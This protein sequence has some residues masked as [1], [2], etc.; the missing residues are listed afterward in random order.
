V[1]APP[2]H[3]AA[4]FS[5]DLL[6]QKLP[7]RGRRSGRLGTPWHR[8]KP[9]KP[10]V[11]PSAGGT[12]ARG[13]AH[14]DASAPNPLAP[15]ATPAHAHLVEPRPGAERGRDGGLHFP[16]GGPAL[17][18]SEQPTADMAPNGSG[19]PNGQA[20]A[21][22]SGERFEFFAAFREAAERAREEAGIDDRRVGQ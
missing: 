16:P 4:I 22:D 3:A 8:E 5:E 18:G 11:L 10:Q 15:A 19:A 20:A 21:N 6:P 9:A 14:A 1:S 2:A 7:K 13:W 12:E 17:V